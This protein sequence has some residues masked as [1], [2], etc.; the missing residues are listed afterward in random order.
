MSKPVSEAVKQAARAVKVV[1]LDVDGVLTDGRL[2][3]SESGHEMKAFN[4]QDGLGI[5]LLQKSGIEVGIITG[6]TSELLKRRAAELG[7]ERL[8]QGRED[9]LTALQEILP[10][11]QVT[12]D[13]IAYMGDDLPDLAVIRRVGFGATVGNGGELVA[14][15]AKWQATRSG[16]EGAVRELAELILAAQDRLDASVSEYF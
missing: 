11:L 7:I 4:I 14:K 12:L 16:G 10:E 3:Y 9:K 13:E 6:R 8:V 15:H 5:K 1:L 2:Y